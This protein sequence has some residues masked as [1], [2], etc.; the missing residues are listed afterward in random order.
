MPK[1]VGSI[2]VLPGSADSYT[3]DVDDV[4]QIHVHVGRIEKL[5]APFDRSIVLAYPDVSQK[6]ACITCDKMG[7]SVQDLGSTNGTWVRGE[8]LDPGTPCRLNAGDRIRIVNYEILIASCPKW[9]HD[10]AKPFP[11]DP[12]LPAL[13]PPTEE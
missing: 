6:H 2:V 4:E 9:L 8:R 3:V 13:S 7:W 5:E 12:T 11:N 1:H 10:T